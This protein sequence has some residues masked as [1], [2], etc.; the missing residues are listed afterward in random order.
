M[1]EKDQKINDLLDLLLD[2][3]PLISLAALDSLLHLPAGDLKKKDLERLATCGIKVFEA[4]AKIALVKFYLK[5]I[6]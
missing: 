1:D 4:F 2:P 3:D 6:K 5:S